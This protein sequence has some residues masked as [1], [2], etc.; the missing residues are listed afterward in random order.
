VRSFIDLFG[1][2]RPVLGMVHLPPLPGSP[3]GGVL[4]EALR[5]AHADAETLTAA[6]IDGLIV[7]NFGDAPFAKER[8]PPATVAAMAI[9]CREMRRDHNVPLGVNVLRNDAEAALSI[10]TVCGADFIRVNVLIG[11][12]VADQGVLEGRAREVLMLRRAL[13]SLALIFADVR[14]K[15]AR[16]LGSDAGIA[17]L[18]AEAKD[19]ASRG[20]ADA[21]IVSGV[22]TGESADP[23]DVKRVKEALPRVPVLVGSGVTE[24]NLERF[25]PFADGIIVGSATKEQNDPHRPVDAARTRAI[26]EAASRLK[27]TERIRG[28]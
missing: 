5:A 11:A 9:V 3:R 12:V 15:H 18:V 28:N 20:G 24:A 25:W 19:A 4:E 27:R 1:G 17:G 14:V 7:E 2:V 8:V 16:P 10:A 21:L 23:D 22:A 13:G 26:L 6:G